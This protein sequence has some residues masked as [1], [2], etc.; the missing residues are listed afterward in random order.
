MT[1]IQQSHGQG[2]SY[3]QGHQNSLV[4]RGLLSLV[5]PFD[6][7]N[8]DTEGSWDSWKVDLQRI[9]KSYPNLSDQQVSGLLHLKL[10][11]EAG[12]V[13]DR[14]DAAGPGDEMVDVD[15]YWDVF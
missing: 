14:V 6:G 2:P 12:W 4:P 3:Q 10:I 8:Q 13:L 1:E 15:Q 5:N 7:V 11:G 9:R